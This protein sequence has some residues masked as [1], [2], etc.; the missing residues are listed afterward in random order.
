MILVI[1][2]DR[3]IRE[4]L[5]QLFEIEGYASEGVS[6]GEDAMRLLAQE[7]RPHPDLIILDLM[8]PV[9]NGYEFRT[10]QLKNSELSKIPTIIISAG[11][12]LEQQA[13]ELKA[14]AYIRK[15]TNIEELMEIVGRFVKK[16]LLKK[17]L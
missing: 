12:D 6:H 9:M 1:E 2:D 7:G 4:S 8:M 10:L 15:P 16:P 17:T 13:G 14:Q 5:L 3:D 11:T